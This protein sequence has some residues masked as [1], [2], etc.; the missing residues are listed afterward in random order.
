MY[1]QQ[2]YAIDR[3]SR[4]DEEKK[5]VERVIDYTDFSYSNMPPFAYID[6]IDETGSL[7]INFGIRGRNIE[8]LESDA[9]ALITI[10]DGKIA[11]IEILLDNKNVI[12]KL[13]KILRPYG[14]GQ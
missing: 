14:Y 5:I 11:D 6:F 7:V 3:D 8:V 2:K 9:L 4:S 1:V 10:I 12:N 13:S